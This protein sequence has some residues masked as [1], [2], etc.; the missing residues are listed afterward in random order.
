MGKHIETRLDI[1]SIVKDLAEAV[2]TQAKQANKLWLVMMA[3]AFIV[4]FPPTSG[5]SAT[6][7]EL[8]FKIA[9][10][11]ASDFYPVVFYLFSVLIIAFATAH[12]QTIRAY[13]LANIALDNMHDS[14]WLTIHPRDLFDMSR[15]SGLNRTAPLAQMLR[16]GFQFFDKSA[17]CPSWLRILTGLYYLILKLA[18]SLVFW[19]LP[20][21][22]YYL[23]WTKVDFL[24]F[25]RFVSL[26]TAVIAGS[27]MAIVSI[28]DIVWILS[29]ARVLLTVKKR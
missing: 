15:T 29:T 6:S 21:I 25:P 4:L 11:S 7:V 23:A 24:G 18:S 9:T 19:V 8:P 14:V 28:S 20:S 10:V 2:S 27:A 22:A 1:P 5:S 17:T 12:A 26:L 16:G 13:K 3:I